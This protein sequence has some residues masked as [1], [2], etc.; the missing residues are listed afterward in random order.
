MCDEGLPEGIAGTLLGQV[1]AKSGL[2]TS[3]MRH[4]L[5]SADTLLS[6]SEP[7]LKADS[8]DEVFRDFH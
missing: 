5:A 7:I 8:R 4:R 3:A 6:W 2:L 1:I